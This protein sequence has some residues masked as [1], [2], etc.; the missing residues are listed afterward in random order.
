MFNILD[1]FLEA[2][3]QE[4]QR[5]LMFEI[6]E[7]QLAFHIGECERVIEHLEKEKVHLLG[8][9]GSHGTPNIEPIDEKIKEYQ[10]MLKS[11]H[12]EHTELVLLIGE[13]N[14]EPE[15][16]GITFRKS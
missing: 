11:H 6:K 3:E 12:D 4:K 9:R 2:D 15:T 10:G 14:Y 1:G 13:E 5:K 7:R 8:I 16:R